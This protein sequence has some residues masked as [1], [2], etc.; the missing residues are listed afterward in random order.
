MAVILSD[1]CFFCCCCFADAFRP[2]VDF[3]STGL[4]ISER[5]SAAIVSLVRLLM[6]ADL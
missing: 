3:A 5:G 1:I 6:V 2:L 4:A